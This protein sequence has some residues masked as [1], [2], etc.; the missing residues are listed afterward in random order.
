MVFENRGKTCQ[1]QGY[2]N[3]GSARFAHACCRQGEGGKSWVGRVRDWVGVGVTVRAL[4]CS[5]RA[6][7]V[8]P[9][10][11]KESRGYQTI[12]IPPTEAPTRLTIHASDCPVPTLVPPADMLAAVTHED[13]QWHSR[14]KGDH[15]KA[16]A[17]PR[18]SPTITP[19]RHLH[20]P[21][22]AI[23]HDRQSER[24]DGSDDHD[25]ECSG[26]LIRI[27]RTSSCHRNFFGL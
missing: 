14:I 4:I 21:G 10:A 26:Y 2:S 19:S 3:L 27:A 15:G 16:P 6:L 12:S 1:S 17:S 8:P 23:L 24:V 5:L 9:Q 13:L 11:R 22:A 25:K 18:D 7:S 20:P